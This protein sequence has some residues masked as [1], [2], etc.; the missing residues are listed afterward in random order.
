LEL[1]HF[2]QYKHRHVNVDNSQHVVLECKRIS[3]KQCNT[4][5]RHWRR[6]IM[7][8]EMHVIFMTKVC[9]WTNLMNLLI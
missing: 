9:K 8:V 5:L 6:N 4:L 3:N 1:V 7:G 2:V